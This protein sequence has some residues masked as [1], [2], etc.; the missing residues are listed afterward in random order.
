MVTIQNKAADGGDQIQIWK[1]YLATP[2]L[3]GK[4]PNTPGRDSKVQESRKTHSKHTLRAV[5]TRF[6]THFNTQAHDYAI[7][8]CINKN[9]IHKLEAYGH[10]PLATPWVHF[11]DL[12]YSSFNMQCI[13][14]QICAWI[15]IRKARYSMHRAWLCQNAW[16]PRAIFQMYITLNTLWKF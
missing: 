4:R 8:S 7:N 16:L 5:L 12:P 10:N 14:E 2:K 15:C 3:W 9:K 13:W 1:E 11:I 6:Y